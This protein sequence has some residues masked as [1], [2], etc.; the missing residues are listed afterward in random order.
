[1]RCKGGV[2]G[3]TPEAAKRPAGHGGRGRALAHAHGPRAR[4]AT[5][6]RA[7]GGGAAPLAA[8]LAL[9][10]Y[11]MLRPSKKGVRSVIL[12]TTFPQ[13]F[14]ESV[15]CGPDGNVCA[16][17]DGCQC[18]R[19][20][21]FCTASGAVLASEKPLL[22]RSR[23]PLARFVAV[24]PADGI[25]PLRASAKPSG[26]AAASVQGSKFRCLTQ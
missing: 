18:L 23:C 15:I 21:M 10:L 4:H 12:Q 8:C 5:A 16:C 9:A 20:P 1:M 3:S 14:E 11:V 6:Q 7:G 25:C 17:C 24:S 22:P 26:G 2:R 13:M 19:V